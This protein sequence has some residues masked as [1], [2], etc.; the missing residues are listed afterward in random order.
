MCVC[1]CA[2]YWKIFFVFVF[3]SN[4]QINSIKPNLVLQTWVEYFQTAVNVMNKNVSKLQRFPEVNLSLCL[5]LPK[6]HI[7]SCYL[8]INTSKFK[9]KH[10][11]NLRFGDT[12]SE[13]ITIFQVRITWFGMF[14]KFFS[15]EPTK[16]D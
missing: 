6:T 14:W 9:R 11:R 10:A 2:K 1:V 12:H 4:N 5:N 3:V 16:C 7:Q 13:S 15:F 8:K